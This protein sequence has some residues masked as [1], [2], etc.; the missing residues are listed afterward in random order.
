MRVNVILE[1]VKDIL[2]ILLLDFVV[3]LFMKIEVVKYE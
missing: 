1:I 3:I 2:F